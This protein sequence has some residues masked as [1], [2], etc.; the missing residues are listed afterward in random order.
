MVFVMLA[1]V[2][3]GVCVLFEG[4]NA[5]LNLPWWAVALVIVDAW[6]LC[7]LSIQIGASLVDKYM[8]RKQRRES[9]QFEL[10]E[11]VSKALVHR[12]AYESDASLMKRARWTVGHNDKLDTLRG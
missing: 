9:T 2:A 3:G 7:E 10:Q 5:Q 1:V 8:V 6:A 12:L 4:L 11:A